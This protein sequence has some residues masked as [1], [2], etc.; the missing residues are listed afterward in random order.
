MDYNNNRGIPNQAI[1]PAVYYIQLVTESQGCNYDSSLT[2]SIVQPMGLL[3]LLKARDIHPAHRRRSRGG[4]RERIS[5]KFCCE[6]LYGSHPNE[7]FT[8][9]NLISATSTSRAA[10]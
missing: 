10:L 1:A 2:G 5:T 4:R 6:V 8:E 9:I 3:S 7:N